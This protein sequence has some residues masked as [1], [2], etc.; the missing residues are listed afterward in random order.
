MLPQVVVGAG[1]AC[2]T[3]VGLRSGGIR[4]IEAGWGAG[5]SLSCSAPPSCLSPVITL[6]PLCTS[7][8]GGLTP[9]LLQ[10]GWCRLAGEGA[11]CHCPVLLEKAG[12]AWLPHPPHGLHV[13]PSIHGAGPAPSSPGAAAPGA[14]AG[15]S[16]AQALFLPCWSRGSAAQGACGCRGRWPELWDHPALALRQQRA[17]LPS[18]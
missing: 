5:G 4:R 7:G 18:P 6:C 3:M 13:C 9:A 8:P 10:Q 17:A 16:V 15:P 1:S 14:V 12:A 2:Y 11:P